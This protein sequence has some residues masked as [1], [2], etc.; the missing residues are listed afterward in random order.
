MNTQP[1]K[2]LLQLI[3]PQYPITTSVDSFF[4]SLAVYAQPLHFNPKKETQYHNVNIRSHYI[5][6]GPGNLNLC[7]IIKNMSNIILD[8]YW[9]QIHVLLQRRDHWQVEL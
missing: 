8:A 2:P 7:N 3:L 9:P 1:M 5:G 4:S 6:P